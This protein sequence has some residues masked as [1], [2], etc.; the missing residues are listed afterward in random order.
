MKFINFCL[1]CFYIWCII[2]YTKK[3]K[4]TD[5]RFKDNEID[6]SEIKLQQK[7]QELIINDLNKE[8][9]KLKNKKINCLHN[10]KYGGF[11]VTPSECLKFEKILSKK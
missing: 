11:L 5:E 1:F 7:R 9:E 3:L 4:D 2:T 10:E 8:I 6:Y